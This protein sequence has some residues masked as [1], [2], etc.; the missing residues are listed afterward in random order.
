MYLLEM[1]DA[2]FI[3]PVPTEFSQ[4]LIGE[5]LSRL[6][7]LVAPKQALK[8][9]F[10][11]GKRWRPS[12]KQM[13]N[14]VLVCGQ[15]GVGKDYFVKGLLPSLGVSPMRKPSI[16]ADVTDVVEGTHDLAT[17]S[18]LHLEQGLDAGTAQQR[19]DRLRLVTER[20]ER[21][22]PT[23]PEGE[24]G[25][26]G[27]I[28]L[29]NASS[30]SREQVERFLQAASQAQY[31]VI[32]TSSSLIAGTDNGRLPNLFG[33]YVLF[34]SSSPSCADVAAVVASKEDAG[35]VTKLE[36]SGGLPL[37]LRSLTI[38]EFIFVSK[39]ASGFG[40]VVPTH[41]RHSPDYF[42]HLSGK[43]RELKYNP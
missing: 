8:R 18:F 24:H 27:V 22:Q 20:L 41:Y 29:E 14:H 23:I 40:M 39:E 30:Y 9:Q 7:R 28:L 16:Y 4:G 38:G 31:V 37:Q 11:A 36:A 6:L 5:G 33:T 19:F 13:F 15:N 25:C 35:F 12:D 42:Q 17:P 2:K 26:N 43:Q 34:K 21:L 10:K 1:Q 3:E 32:G